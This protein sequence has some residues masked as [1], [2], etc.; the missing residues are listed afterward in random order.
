MSNADQE[1]SCSCRVMRVRF[2]RT[3]AIMRTSDQMRR[4]MATLWNDMVRL[5]KRIRKSRW[6]WPSQKA[7]DA[8]FVRRKDR[9]VGLP[10]ACVQ[11]AVR[12]FFG[13]I[14]TTRENRKLGLSARYPWRDQK[15]FQTV[16]FR[17]DLVSWSS[18]QLTL[19]GG[20]GSP[21]LSIPLGEDPGTILKAE[22]LFDEVLVTAE[23]PAAAPVCDTPLEPATAAGDP[24]Q[25]WAWALLSTNGASLMINGR[26]IVAEK[27]RREK[28]RAYQKAYQAR[29]KAGSRRL[30][31]TNRTMARQKAK[32]V[33]RIRDVNHKV[34]RQVVDWGVETG[35]TRMILSQP[36]GIAKAKGRK[37]QKQRNGY[38]EYGEQSRMIEYKAEGLIEIERDEERGTSSTCPKCNH[39]YHPS[40]RT[41]L[42]P[43]CG[44]SGHRDLVGSGN[45]L[46]RHEPHADVAAMIEQAHPK[47]LR[48]WQQGR[49]SVD[50]TDR[51]TGRP[52]TRPEEVAHY[53][54]VGSGSPG[55]TAGGQHWETGAE[56]LLLNRLWCEENS[57][58]KARPEHVSPKTPGLQP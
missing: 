4:S 34:S 53:K 41:F 23:Y 31:K 44:W 26:A 58:N 50:E 40:G 45:Q 6:K 37:S 8:H 9:Y 49:S 3:P 21:A 29:R 20:N 30:K 15:H 47:Y 42:C 38:W 39:C 14:K 55:T 22:L 33:R 28:K 2:H 54:A 5:H 1:P 48:P 13:N 35:Q 10:S 19:G 43:N 52:P 46:G 18:G 11:Q 25:R 16:V 57:W 51:P 7:F 27:I 12:K 32:S 36:T 24:G 17:G 56:R